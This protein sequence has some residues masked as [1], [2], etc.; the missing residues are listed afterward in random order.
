[1]IAAIAA[2]VPGCPPALDFASDV[3]LYVV[4]MFCT[5]VGTVDDPAVPNVLVQ[6]P[7]HGAAAAVVPLDV[8]RRDHALRPLPLDA[9]LMRP[10]ARW[11]SFLTGRCRAQ[12]SEALTVI[13]GA[14]VGVRL[15]S[16]VCAHSQRVSRVRRR[17]RM[18]LSVSHF[19]TRERMLLFRLSFLFF[20]F[21]AF[22]LVF[23]PRRA[24]SSHLA[25]QGALGVDCAHSFVSQ[26]L[27]AFVH[28]KR[29]ESVQP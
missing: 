1:M 8:Q 20:L 19:F 11:V 2:G 27:D 29:Q 13:E 10:V 23:L 26:S 22:V 3:Q 4:L 16:A 25:G 21:S 14:A 7:V 9:A 12:L 6:H 18:P 28:S 5:G 15:V 17:K 24:N